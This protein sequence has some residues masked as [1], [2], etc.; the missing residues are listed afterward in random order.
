MAF[1]ERCTQRRGC[2]QKEAR[3][4]LTRGLAVCLLITMGMKFYPIVGT[5]CL[6]MGPTV[7]VQIL[8]R[9]KLWL[10]EQIGQWSDLAQVWKDTGI[11]A[12]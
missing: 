1:T 12:R 6:L 11:S 10:C 2:Y 3:K 7:G 4:S 8:P 5:K 9:G